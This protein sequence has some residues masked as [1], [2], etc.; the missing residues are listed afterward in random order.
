VG[1]YMR[2]PVIALVLLGVVW[3]V[4]GCATEARRDSRS[5]SEVRRD[6]DRFFEKMKEEERGRPASGERSP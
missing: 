2:V 4:Y 6:S 3:S 1:D 5:N